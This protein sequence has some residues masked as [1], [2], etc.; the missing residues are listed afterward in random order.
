MDDEKRGGGDEHFRKFKIGIGFQTVSGAEALPLRIFL[1]YIAR[2]VTRE[3]H[4]CVRLTRRGGFAGSF[5]FCGLLRSLSGFEL[6]NLLVM[7]QRRKE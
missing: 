7:G 3:R 5:V 2:E 6:H 1:S 4:V